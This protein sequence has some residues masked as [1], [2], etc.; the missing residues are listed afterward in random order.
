[1]A[2]ATVSTCDTVAV[3]ALKKS[4]VVG[5]YMDRIHTP[6]DTILDEKNVEI[7][8]MGMMNYINEI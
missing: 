4:K 6:K 3:A 1:M 2:N 8:V 7:L 5:L